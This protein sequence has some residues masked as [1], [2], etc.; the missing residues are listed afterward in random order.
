[1]LLQESV[2]STRLFV[3]VFFFVAFLFVLKFAFFHVL[4]VSPSFYLNSVDL[5]WI[6]RIASSLLLQGEKLKGVFISVLIDLNDCK[7]IT[8]IW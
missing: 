1:M 8:M 5:P 6:M 4:M 2:T 3:S 7:L